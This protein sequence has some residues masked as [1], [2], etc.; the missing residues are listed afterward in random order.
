VL[1][2][3]GELGEVL[4]QRPLGGR[5]GG[6]VEVLK[7]LRSREGGVADPVSGSRGITREDLGLQQGLKELLVAPA[8]LAGRACGLIESLWNSPARS[9]TVSLS[10]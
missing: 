3:P 9:D 5:L 6:E 7:A 10:G 1:V 4:D 2:Y 8:V